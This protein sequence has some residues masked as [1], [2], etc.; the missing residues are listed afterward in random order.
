VSAAQAAAF[1]SEA[2]QGA[3]VW[4]V[5]DV[6]GFPAPLNADGQR[7]QPFWSMRS[8]AERIVQQVEAYAGFTIESIP[9]EAFRGR[10]LPG[11]ER[12]GILVG[13]NWS[14]TKA[15]GYDV[16]APDVERNLAAAE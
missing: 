13:L 1:Y 9:L 2:L 10:W 14:G 7:V 5:R 16:T 6:D 15:T 12:D 3:F 4:T 8:R 11:L